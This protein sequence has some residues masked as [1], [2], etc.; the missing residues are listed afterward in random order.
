MTFHDKFREM[1]LW[2]VPLRSLFRQQTPIETD[3]QTDLTILPEPSVD[4]LKA[5]LGNSNFK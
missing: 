3:N 4:M 1:W 5:N 2:L